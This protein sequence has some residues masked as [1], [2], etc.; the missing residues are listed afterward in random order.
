MRSRAAVRA[1]GVSV[2]SLPPLD[3]LP[4]AV[5]VEDAAVVVDEVAVLCAI[6]P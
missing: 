4:D 5:F 3:D 2:V 1:A 6:T